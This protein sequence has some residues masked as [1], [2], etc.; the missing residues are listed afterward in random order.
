MKITIVTILLLT[1]FIAFSQQANPV[2]FQLNIGTSVS[3][4]YQRHLETMT[5]FSGHPET[6]YRSNLGFFGEVLTGK[7]INERVDL[8]A[9]LQYNFSRIKVHD[10]LGALESRGTINTGYLG[11]P[12]LIK[13]KISDR[14]PFSVSLGPTFGYILTAREKGTMKIDAS[15][16][17][18]NNDDI[19]ISSDPVFSYDN[20]IRDNY[21]HFD[22]GLSTQ[23][24]YHLEISS[25]L[26]LILFTR[27]NLG[28]IDVIAT[29][30]SLNSSAKKWKQ[31]TLFAG[32]GIEF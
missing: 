21:T 25:R 26:G 17:S 16:L 4:P 29:D 9:G 27:L 6:D 30:T 32:L 7:S 18:E 28:M 8:L 15:E 2:S 13:Y 12:L 11:L 3:I 23:F 14:V 10:Q 1:P 19:L 20:N 31:H 5:E 24:D 22:V